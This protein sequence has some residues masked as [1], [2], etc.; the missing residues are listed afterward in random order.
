MLTATSENQEDSPFQYYLYFE[1]TFRKWDY[2]SLSEC[3]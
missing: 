1:L 3:I 2:F